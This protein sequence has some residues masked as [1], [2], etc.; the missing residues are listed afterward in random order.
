MKTEE[1]ANRQLNKAL[2][3]NEVNYFLPSNFVKLLDL[4]FNSMG[5]IQ[6]SK[7][8]DGDL[9]NGFIEKMI[10]FIKYSSVVVPREVTEVIKNA[11]QIDWEY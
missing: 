4:Y 9:I 7:I 2:G 11:Q 1:L 3:T 10:N 5:I 8:N 6:L